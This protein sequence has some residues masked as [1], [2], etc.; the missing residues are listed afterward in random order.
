MYRSL[1]LLSILLLGTGCASV[2]SLFEAPVKE[3]TPAAAEDP[4]R[5]EP[6]ELPFALAQADDYVVRVVAENATC[7]GTLIA[8]DLVLT[9]H[10]CVAQRDISGEILEKDLE[11]E[12]LRVELGGDYLPWGEVGVDA[13]VT[14]PCGH[15]AG[16]GDI[17][18]LVLER[19][20]IGMTT[21]D[22]ELDHVPQSGEELHTVGFGRCSLSGEAIHRKPRP[23]GR[24][25]KVKESRYTLEASICPGDSGGPALNTEGELV[26]VV[27]RSVM[28]GSEQTVNLSEFTRLDA[29][30]GLFANARAISD[31][32][33]AAELPPVAGCS[34]H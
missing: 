19:K 15:R 9:A 28:D 20:L 30:R 33:S 6:P 13:V 27:S 24:V 3:P 16:V 5:A 32:A 17:A 2:S 8:D 1:P 14:P 34:A 4:G 31:G 18:I 12:E 26:G 21:L 29:F 25:L 22:P 10:H 23:G 7:T 11:P